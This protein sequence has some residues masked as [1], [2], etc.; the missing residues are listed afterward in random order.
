MLL[1][2]AGVVLGL[3]L[4]LFVALQIVG[5]TL[6][7]QYRSRGSFVV[8]ATPEEVFDRLSDR[9]AAPMSG[10]MTKSSEDLPAK[11]RRPVWK[12][13]LGSD[14][15][16]VTTIASERPRKI[17]RELAAEVVSSMTARVEIGI[18]PEGEGSRVSVDWTNSLP[19]G[20][21]HVPVFRCMLTMTGGSKG[22]I[23]SYLAH[24]FAEE[25]PEIEW[26]E[27]D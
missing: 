12:E 16:R 27:P 6:P 8:A 4:L 23:G 5:R 25:K 22:S 14:R 24:A 10:D 7:E 26:S 2:I 17:V 13:D 21:W 3:P 9:E 18:E 19:P 11:G 15:I 1:W 20:T